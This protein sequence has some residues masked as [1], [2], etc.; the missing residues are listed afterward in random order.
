MSQSSTITDALTCPPVERFLHGLEIAN[1]QL[2]DSDGQ[3][4]FHIGCWQMRPGVHWVHG[5]SGAGKTRL[6][7]YLASQNAHQ[8][9]ANTAPLSAAQPNEAN[10][11]PL[12]IG[13]HSPSAQPRP[14]SQKEVFFTEPEDP[15]WDSMTVGEV[16]AQL[17]ASGAQS[18]CHLS[19]TSQARIQADL[20]A[21]FGLSPHL[22]KAMYMLSTGTRRK[23]FLLAAVLAPQPLVLL[24]EPSAA[25]DLRSIQ[26][27]HYALALRNRIAQHQVTLVATAIEPQGHG[28]IGRGHWRLDPS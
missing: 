14:L 22:H 21:G 16:Q 26:A 19:A 7:R 24:D 3:P 12:A 13:W 11:G 9:D 5:T 20:L 15:T 6:L 2:P 1:L 8:D 17:L 18:A 10:A 28:Q 27:L 4:L 23:V 25:L